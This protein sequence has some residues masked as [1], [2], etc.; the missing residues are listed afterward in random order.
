MQR[1]LGDFPGAGG[2]GERETR[3]FN[4]SLTLRL[5][6]MLPKAGQGCRWVAGTR[7]APAKPRREGIQLRPPARRAAHAAVS[8]CA[9]S[10]FRPGGEGRRSAADFR[11]ART[12][13]AGIAARRGAG[14]RGLETRRGSE[15]PAKPGA[16]GAPSPPCPSPSRRPCRR[17]TAARGRRSPD[18]GTVCGDSDA[19]QCPKG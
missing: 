17:G 9:G 1:H 6:R 3:L 16:A 5:G 7:P 12:C 14:P 11:F 15:S 13:G 2:G 10:R 8:T 19:S 4:P 18:D